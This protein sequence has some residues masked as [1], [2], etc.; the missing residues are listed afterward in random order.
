MGGQI[1]QN[2]CL[3]YLGRIYAPLL[4]LRLYVAFRIAAEAVCIAQL[5]HVDLAQLAGGYHRAHLLEHI[6]TGEAVGYS[7]NLALFLCQLL[8][9]FALLSLKEQRLL[10]DNV[11]ASF[12]SCLGYFV[13]QEIRGCNVNDFDAVLT[14]CFFLEHRLVIR[15]AAICIH[16]EAY[17]ELSAALC[18][19][20]KCSSSEQERGVVAH[21]AQTMLIAYL[22]G[23]ASA[24]DTPTERSV[25]QFL[26]NVHT[27][28]FLSCFSL[29]F[30]IA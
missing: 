2:E 17:T 16:A 6:E 26:A 1:A 12:Q 13:M 21:R 14:L 28:Y 24:Y 8:D 15:I 22:R 9:F 27:S 20:I 23:L 29:C 10:T 25:N 3:A 4:T 7:N 11:Q 30:K 5:D 18:V 19:Y